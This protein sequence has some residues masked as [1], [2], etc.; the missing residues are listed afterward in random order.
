MFKNPLKP[1]FPIRN[2][3]III[4]IGCVWIVI[5]YFLFEKQ[6]LMDYERLLVFKE[7]N[8]VFFG[9][10]YNAKALHLAFK[11]IINIS[12]TSKY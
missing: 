1:G 8:L 4:C 2:I 9:L 5:R 12:S 7:Y 3:L 6:L 11:L 10:F